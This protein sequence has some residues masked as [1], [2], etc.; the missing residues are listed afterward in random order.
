MIFIHSLTH[1]S[2]LGYSS[3]RF[4]ASKQ[5]QASAGSLAESLSLLGIVPFLYERGPQA[6]VRDLRMNVVPNVLQGI[7]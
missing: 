5:I 4:D 2:V 1:T 7:R 3:T 6:V